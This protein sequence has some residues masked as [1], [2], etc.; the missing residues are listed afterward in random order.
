M[1]RT[2][3]ET[4]RVFARRARE[5]DSWYDDSLLFAIELAALR[6]LPPLPRPSLEIGVGPGRFARELGIDF[7]LDPALPPL[8]IA[9]QRRISPVAGTGEAIPL[10]S[11]CLGGIV[12]LFTL[13][14][15]VDPYQTLAECHRVLS[16]EGV[17]MVGMIPA[18]SSWGRMLRQKKRNRHPFYRAAEFR[19][20]RQTAELL[21]QAGFTVTDSRSTLRQP[22]GAVNGPEEARTGIDEQA[23]FCVFRAGKRS[24]P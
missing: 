23:G 5:Y 4:S 3:Q 17:L 12:L 8:R 15:L 21:N 18:D 19:S 11:G 16:D 13:C 7:G 14:F 6:T 1:E 20:A 2:W 22:P 24:E 10:K 9:A